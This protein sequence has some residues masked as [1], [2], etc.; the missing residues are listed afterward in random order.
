M[1]LINLQYKGGCY[2]FTQIAQEG[3]NSPKRHGSKYL[4]NGGKKITIINSP[5][6]HNCV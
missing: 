1:I 5:V 4:K 6:D 2:A 3:K